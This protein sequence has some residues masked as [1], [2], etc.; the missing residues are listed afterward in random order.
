MGGAKRSPLRRRFER[1]EARISAE[2]VEVF[3]IDDNELARTGLRH[4]LE[5]DRN[6]EMIGAAPCTPEG[7]EACA[8][9]H[10]RIVLVDPRRGTS[11]ELGTLRALRRSC[12]KSRII[13]FTQ[14][15]DAEYLFQA[16]RAG[17]A[18]CVLKAATHG[19][20]LDYLEAALLGSIPMNV[21]PV[22][23]LADAGAEQSPAWFAY[24]DLT[25]RERDVLR[26]L[27][28]G[29]TNPE[30]ATDLCLSLG[31]VKVHVQNI[32]MKMNASGR[33]D[34]AV[35]ATRLGLLNADLAS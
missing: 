27:V 28:Q 35:R 2:S 21:E 6:F 9:L 26:L 14:H 11:S 18:G 25:I 10:P 19:E 23:R 3:V 30:I 12:P 4:M 1:V 34:A 5:G 20:L 24:P 7:I 15:A 13:V 8:A 16:I 22:P 33:T 31:T 17:A 32:I 29:R